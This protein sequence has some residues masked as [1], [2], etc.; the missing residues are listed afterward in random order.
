[1]YVQ[2]NSEAGLGNRYGSVQDLGSGAYLTPGWDGMG[3]NQ[4]PDPE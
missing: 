1:M 2:T 4:D 3:K